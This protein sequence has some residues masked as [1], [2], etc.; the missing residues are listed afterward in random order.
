MS[1]VTMASSG[2]HAGH[3]AAAPRR[4]LI[5]WRPSLAFREARSSFQA[6]AWPSRSWRSRV[7]ARRAAVPG[8][9]DGAKIA[10]A[11]AL[12]SPMMP[13]STGYLRPI[14]FG[15]MSTCTIFAALREPVHRRTA[16]A[17]R[18]PRAA[19]R[20]PAPRRP[21]RAASSRPWSP[22]SRAGRPPGRG[23]PGRRRCAGRRPPRA[24]RDARRWPCTSS[25]ASASTTPL[26]AMITGFF[27]F[28]RSS[29]ARSRDSGP[30]SACRPRY[31]SGSRISSSIS[32]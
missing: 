21:R 31:W 28:A 13:T 15:L 17:C 27:A 22:C 14:C 5:G 32:P 18:T 24:R 9:A 23:L 4:G 7:L 10:C 19:C 8:L 3:L 30:G 25:M 20:A 16:G 11:A 2:R 12:A 1:V 26:P 29:A 6:C